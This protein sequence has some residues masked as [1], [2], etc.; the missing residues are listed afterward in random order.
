MV[1][2]SGR[3]CDGV[4]L[5]CWPLRFGQEGWEGRWVRW[6]DVACEMGL[7]GLLCALLSCLFEYSPLA[8]WVGYSA[9][10]F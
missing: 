7:I 2:D 4:R 8:G 9:G 6:F 10:F 1:G 3:F 5:R